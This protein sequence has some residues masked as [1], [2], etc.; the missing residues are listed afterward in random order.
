M[1]CTLSPCVSTSES[2]AVRSAQTAAV[3]Y[4]FLGFSER[5]LHVGEAEAGH[6][7]ELTHH[8]HEL[9]AQLL[10]SLLL[11]FQLLRG[12]ND[13]GDGNRRKKSKESYSRPAL[14]IV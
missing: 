12:K 8:R 2:D 4:Q 1:G 9:V 5:V 6:G 14:N 11:I 10:R 3:T 13:P 7:D